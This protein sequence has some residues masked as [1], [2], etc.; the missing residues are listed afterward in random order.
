[1]ERRNRAKFIRR[2][3][4]NASSNSRRVR[5]SRS[6]ARAGRR[7]RRLERGI[8]NGPP[9]FRPF[10]L[11]RDEDAVSFR[12]GNEKTG[13]LSR[14][15]RVRIRP[16]N[17]P[18]RSRARQINDGEF[19]AGPIFLARSAIRRSRNGNELELAKQMEPG[20]R[21][22]DALSAR[23][24]RRKAVLFSYEHRFRQFYD[25]NGRKVHE[26]GARVRNVSEFFQRGR[27]DEA[28]F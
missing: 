14:L 25:G 26:T 18:R 16:K 3:A 1:M 15:G 21:S 13:D 19:D 24:L 20:L 7:I 11:R 27:G 28:I 12:R 9:R 8:R 6:D 22:N 4:A 17:V 5:R 2:R 10:A 23:S